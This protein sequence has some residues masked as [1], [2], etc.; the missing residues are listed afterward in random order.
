MGKLR[1]RRFYF[2]DIATSYEL[3][4]ADPATKTVVIEPPFKAGK[5]GSSRECLVSNAIMDNPH[6]FPHPVY[7]AQTIKSRTDIVDK[8]KKGGTPSHVVVYQHNC[9][10]RTN[11]ND[12][13]N[14]TQEDLETPI[15]LKPL[16]Q[17]QKYIVGSET[18]GSS[19]VFSKLCLKGTR[20]RALRAKLIPDEELTR[21]EREILG[22]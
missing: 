3:L 2:N 13:E 8:K 20:A 6:V 15:T 18:G 9:G 7:G 17:K 1:P 14:L 16:R 21:R 12:D 4:S 11:A 5:P 22:K 19:R 10:K